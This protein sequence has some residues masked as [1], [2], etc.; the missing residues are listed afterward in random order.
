M[1][2]FK[3][4]HYAHFSMSDAGEIAV[5]T[6]DG[7]VKLARM[8]PAAYGVKAA[9]EG[10]VVRFTVPRPMALVVH[11]DFRE[12]LF[13]FADPP[14][15]PVPADAVN[16][17]TLGA[18]GDGSTDNTAVLQK[19]I[20]DLPEDGTLLLPAGHFRSGS[21]RLRECESAPLRPRPHRLDEGAQRRAS[22]ATTTTLTWW[23]A[24]MSR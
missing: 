24:P 6:L 14:A 13:L 15:D 22:L 17:A 11:L 1:V 21:L 20:D 19:A 2:A 7:P 16:A 18:V 23:A 9:V 10:A 4:V 3:D 8:Q 12:K 5:T